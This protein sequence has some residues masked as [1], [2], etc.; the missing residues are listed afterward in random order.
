MIVRSITDDVLWQPFGYDK[1]PKRG[2]IWNKITPKKVELENYLTRE[3]AM[4]AT[5]DI[6]HG[7]KASS[8]SKKQKAKLSVDIL[9]QLLATTK[10]MFNEDDFIKD[11]HSTQDSL[12]KLKKSENINKTLIFRAKEKLSKDALGRY[13]VGI[14]TLM[15]DDSQRSYILDAG[16]TSDMIDKAEF[17]DEFDVSVETEDRKKLAKILTGIAF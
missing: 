12:D 7:I 1:V 9:Q 14:D 10:S 6:M 17:A 4:M 2:A 8:L 11:M 16:F 3:L 13:V 15:S 5:L